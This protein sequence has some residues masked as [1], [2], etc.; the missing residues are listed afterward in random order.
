[1]SAPLYNYLSSIEPYLW[2]E[3][4]TYPSD[5]APLNTLFTN[6]EA[7]LTMTFSGAGIGSMIASGQLPSTAKV[8]CMNTSVA[9]TNYV[10]IPFNAN[11]KA[12]AMVVANILLQPEQQADWVKLTGNGPG[13]NVSGLSG[14]RAEAMNSVLVNQTAGT[15]VPAAEL[16]ATRAPDL[17]GNLITYLEKYWDKKIG[18]V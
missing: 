11:A 15:Y 1:M 9:N 10:A 6:G 16:A 12:G 13:I 5:I 3:G 8:Y 14:W 2:N 17:S 4:K 7:S 18:S